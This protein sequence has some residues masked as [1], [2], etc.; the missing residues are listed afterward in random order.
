[1]QERNRNT[2]FVIYDLISRF[3][4][5]FRLSH[6]NSEPGKPKLG[7]KREFRC[8]AQSRNSVA[9]PRRMLDF[10]AEEAFERACLERQRD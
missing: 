8:A 10:Q 7:W 4:P 1:M 3:T 2:Y 9:V 6:R 5:E